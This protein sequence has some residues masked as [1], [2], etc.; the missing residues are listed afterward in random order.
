MISYKNKSKES[1]DVLVLT[2]AVWNSLMVPIEL[3]LNPS[4]IKHPFTQFLDGAIDLMFL[5]DMILMFFTSFVTKSGV[6]EWDS[7]QVALKYVKSFRF[8]ADFLSLLGTG[9]VT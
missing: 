3:T 2:L 5:V 4:F 7:K 6:E 8:V 9:V 1:W